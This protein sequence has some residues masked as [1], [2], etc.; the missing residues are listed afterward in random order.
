MQRNESRR[1]YMYYGGGH[2]IDKT[3]Q[4]LDNFLDTYPFPLAILAKWLYNV[5]KQAVR[6]TWIRFATCE[7]DYVMFGSRAGAQSRE[8]PV[9]VVTASPSFT[10]HNTP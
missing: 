10:Q 2:W 8:L 9:T 1:R 7:N 3:E 4:D 5:Y 6:C